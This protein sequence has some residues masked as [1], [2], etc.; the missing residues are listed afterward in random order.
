MME[1]QR[2][3]SSLSRLL[4]CNHHA[5]VPGTGVSIKDGEEVFIPPGEVHLDRVEPE[6][7]FAFNVEFDKD[8]NPDLNKDA[9]NPCHNI[10]AYT[11]LYLKIFQVKVPMKNFFFNN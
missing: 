8:G 1:N 3:V 9:T 7:V 6:D 10:S 4:H 2:L 5:I 11:S